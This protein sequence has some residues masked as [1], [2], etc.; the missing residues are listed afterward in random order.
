MNYDFPS[1]LE[2]YCHRVGRA[3]RQYQHDTPDMT[4]SP[5]AGGDIVGEAYSLLTRNMAPLAG[6]LVQLLMRCNQV[7]EPNLLQLVNDY[8]SGG[9]DLDPGKHDESHGDT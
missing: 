3:G 9:L 4:R 2:Q 6:D 7:V 5:N 8:K 1:S